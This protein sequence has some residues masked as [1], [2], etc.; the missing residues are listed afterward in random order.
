MPPAHSARLSILLLILA[1]V[2]VLSVW[3]S[4]TAIL[5]ALALRNGLAPSDLAELA[6]ATQA[7]FVFGALLLATTGLSDRIDPRRLFAVSSAATAAANLALLWVSPD[8]LSALLSRFLVGALLAGVYP[9]GLKIAMGW[10]R[11]NRGLLASLLVGALTLGSASPQ[12]VTYLGGA[13]PQYVLVTTSLAACIGGCLILCIGL[14]PYHAMS[15]EFSPRSLTLV[16]R[17]PALR[18]AYFGYFGHMWELYAYWAWAPTALLASGI[19]GDTLNGTNDTASQAAGLTF[20]AM[21]LGAFACLPSGRLADRLGKA[22]V[23]RWLLLGSGVCAL[24]AAV[25][26][27]FSPT[28]FLIAV[29]GWGMFVIPDSPLFSAMVADAAP[30]DKAGSLLT[31]QTALG[32]AL[33]IVSVQTTP[34][35]AEEFGWNWAI[36]LLAIGPF[37]GAFLVSSKDRGGKPN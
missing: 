28:V 16:I 25:S 12:L 31:L 32:F 37:I 11:Q 8:T 6:T 30:A 21:C 20:L 22:R 34:L 2:A 19:L 33:T 24:V 36:S 5:P 23:A 14:G 35:I 3:F 13:D 7:G 10:S 17:E 26:V 18:R 9:V 15:G 29:L 1:Q 27:S 4:A